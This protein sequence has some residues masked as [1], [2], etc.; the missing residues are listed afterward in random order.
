[1]SY[2]VQ[3]TLSP[4]TLERI[5]SASLTRVY[6]AWKY[7]SEFVRWFGATDQR[8]SAT[9]LDFRVGGSWKAIFGP[10]DSPETY[11][12]GEYLEIEENAKIV[13]TWNYVRCLPVSAAYRSPESIVTVTFEPH[14]AGTRLCLEQSGVLREEAQTNVRS[15]WNASLTLLHNRLNHP[16]D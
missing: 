2:A 5:Y 6:S 1:M 3:T 4:I 9:H 15:G 10:S 8:P 12:V 16:A 13:F 14:G 7:E 11:L